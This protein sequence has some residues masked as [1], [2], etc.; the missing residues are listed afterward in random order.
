MK[1]YL[2]FEDGTTFTGESFASVGNVVGNAVFTTE[3]V[4]FCETLCDPCYEGQILI[5]TFP[6]IGCAGINLSDASFKPALAAYV[7]NTPCEYPSSFRCEKTLEEFLTENGIVGMKNADTRAITKYITTHGVQKARLVTDP[8]V[9]PSAEQKKKIASPPYIAAGKGNL[10]KV[11]C[12]DFGRGTD[13]VSP[14]ERRNCEITVFGADFSAEK[15]IDGYDGV[16]LSDGYGRA[17]KAVLKKINSLAGKIPLFGIGFGHLAL[18]ESFGAKVVTLAHGHHGSVPVKSVSGKVY[19]NPQ[20]HLFAVN[21][22]KLPKIMKIS[23]LNV[24]DGS[25]EGL[26]YPSLKAFSVQFRPGDSLALDD[27]RSIYDKFV[28][29]MKE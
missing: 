14:L 17:D 18:A 29:L 28:A 4:G 27:G 20:N 21:R 2:I 12:I 23:H 19:V 26:E 16:V 10:Y 6:E 3:V 22:E 13:V 8:S 24:N 7:I 25:I 1:T 5:Q 15:V 9:F 11:A